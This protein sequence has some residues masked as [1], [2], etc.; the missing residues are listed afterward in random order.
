[1][2]EIENMFSKKI[3]SVISLVSLDYIL[4]KLEIGGR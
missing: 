1:M 3:N 4:G 2:F